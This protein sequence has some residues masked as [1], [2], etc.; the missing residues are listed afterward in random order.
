MAGSR[1]RRRELPSM[2]GPRL[3]AVPAGPADAGAVQACLDGAPGY[4]IRTEGAR[5]AADHADRL[6]SDAEADPGRRVYLLVPPRGGAALGVLDLHLDHPGPGE[7]H[8][9]LLL[10]RE[11]CQGIGYGGETVAALAHALAEAGFRAVHAS[12]GDENPEA[13]AFWEH[14]GFGEAGR[15]AGGVTVL[16]RLLP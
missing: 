8:V 13:R 11:S 15:L 6:L 10:F 12:V 2:D 7:A 3:R 16:E 9:G 14:A 1:A 4:F 5:A